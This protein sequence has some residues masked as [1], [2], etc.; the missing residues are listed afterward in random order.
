MLGEELPRWIEG[1]EIDGGWLG[2]GQWS[3]SFWCILRRGFV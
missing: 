3:R 2:V 1:T